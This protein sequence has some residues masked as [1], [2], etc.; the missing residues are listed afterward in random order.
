[1][2]EKEKKKRKKK[3]EN[4]VLSKITPWDER[5]K[6]HKGGESDSF[7]DMAGHKKVS[8]FYADLKNRASVEQETTAE[9]T[10]E[11]V[12]QN[13]DDVSPKFKEAEEIVVKKYEEPAKV[14]EYKKGKIEIEEDTDVKVFEKENHKQP[15]SKVGRITQRTQ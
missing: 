13:S 14:L 3:E 11:E 9:E 15:T 5:R 1:M 8:D 10:V 2:S 7:E 4:D 6:M 12:P